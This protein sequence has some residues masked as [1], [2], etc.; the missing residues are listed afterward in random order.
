[1]RIQPAGR[2]G[3]DHLPFDLHVDLI[4]TIT[5]CPPTC[6]SP[7]CHAVAVGCGVGT[8]LRKLDTDWIAGQIIVG[9]SKRLAD[10]HVVLLFNFNVHALAAGGWKRVLL[11]R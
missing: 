10:L 9:A 1:M 8:R 4:P 6:P 3:V 5:P 2:E 7:P 11:R